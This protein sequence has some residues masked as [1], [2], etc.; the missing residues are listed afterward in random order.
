MKGHSVMTLDEFK[1][2]NKQ[3]R[4]EK[5]PKANRIIHITHHKDLIDEVPNFRSVVRYVSS[6]GFVTES[7]CAGERI[8]K[9]KFF[10]GY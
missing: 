1:Y 9:I 10:F 3:T 8:N 4:K 2:T 5:V 6:P 7:T